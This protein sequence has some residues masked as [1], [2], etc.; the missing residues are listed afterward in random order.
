MKIGVLDL[1]LGNLTSVLA[2]VQRADLEPILIERPEQANGLP[3]LILPGVGALAAG[4]QALRDRRFDRLMEQVVREQRPV[5]GICLGMQLYFAQGDE[6]GSGMGL[7]E[8]GVPRLQARK[9]PHI[10]WNQIEP[11]DPHH[12]L[13]RDIPP[14]TFFYFVHS[15]AVAPE[16][17]TDILAVTTYDQPFVSMVA[18]PPLYGV[19]FHP[20]RSGAQGKLLLRNFG[21]VV[22][23]C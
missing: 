20:E 21:R 15:F 10:G 6:G 14:Q 3:G 23:S 12:P 16:R 22:A 2:G 5:L 1:G 8:G 7:L 19:Q 13:L 4:R 18:R 9:L 11:T 17:K